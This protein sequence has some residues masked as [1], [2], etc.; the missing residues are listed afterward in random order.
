V[1]NYIVEECNG[2]KMN[3]MPFYRSTDISE[4]CKGAFKYV[5]LWYSCGEYLL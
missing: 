5:A 1:K 3:C 2:K 4:N